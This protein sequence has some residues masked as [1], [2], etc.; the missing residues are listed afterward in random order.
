ML[1]LLGSAQYKAP[2]EAAAVSRLGMILRAGTGPGGECIA[3][4]Q[5]REE[6]FT[7]ADRRGELRKLGRMGSGRYYD[8]VDYTNT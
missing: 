2:S 3:A 1:A 8:V 6:H 5:R 7:M 4:Q